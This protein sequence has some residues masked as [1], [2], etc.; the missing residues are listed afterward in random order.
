MPAVQDVPYLTYELAA[1]YHANA[2]EHLCSHLLADFRRC[3]LLYRLKT[4]GQ[5]A[6]E[7]RPAYLLCRAAHTLILEGPEAFEAQ[8]AVGSPINPATGRRYG[9]S[10]KAFAEWAASQG[11]PVLTDEQAELIARMNS[12]VHEHPVAAKLLRDGVAEAVVRNHYCDLPC[13]IRMDW[14]EPHTG[15][16]DLKT[17]DQLDYFEADARRFGYV[18]Q[19]AFYQAVLAQ[20]IGL[21]VPVHLIAV[22]KREPFRCGVWRVSQDALAIAR[23]DNEAAIDRLKEC[24]AEDRWPT[25]YEEVRMF[26]LV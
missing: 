25:G 2:G 19:L 22:E 18:H 5:L 13:Q 14:F 8:Y 16:V 3:P 11:R 26:D 20:V 7:D 21:A 17:C 6:D 9:S 10:T 23:Q 24:L 4:T 12:A 15:V 1:V